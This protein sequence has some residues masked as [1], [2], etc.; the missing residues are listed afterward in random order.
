MK[1]EYDKNSLKHLT[2]CFILSAFLGIEGAFA[3]MGA[4]LT[5]EYCDN[6]YTKS[7]SW[8]DIFY[9]TLGTC[10]GVIVHFV[11]TGRTQL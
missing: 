8:W 11:V 7:W 2:I 5:K 3:A 1:I 10:L 9:D 4:G 6:I